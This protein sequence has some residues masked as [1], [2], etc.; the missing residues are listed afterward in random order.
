MQLLLRIF[1]RSICALHFVHLLWRLSVLSLFQS[2]FLFIST[3]TAIRYN[4]VWAAQQHLC[5]IG[6]GFPKH[7]SCTRRLEQH[8]FEER[9]A[10][11]NGSNTRTF[12]FL[13]FFLPSSP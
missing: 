8:N 6:F 5:F 10:S 12:L 7:E 13:F 1:I 3:P 4:N 9:R 2:F 11:S